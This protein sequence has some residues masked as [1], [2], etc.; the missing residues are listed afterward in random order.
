LNDTT[1]MLIVGNFSKEPPV[2]DAAVTSS[3]GQPFLSAGF[4]GH[5]SD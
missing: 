2:E 1:T 5:F 4:G 3:H